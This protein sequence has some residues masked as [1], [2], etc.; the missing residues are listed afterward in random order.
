MV[1]GSIATVHDCLLPL[2]AARIMSSAIRRASRECVVRVVGA[3]RLA[4][5]LLLLPIARRVPE[6]ND[7]LPFLVEH[8]F[9]QERA[10]RRRPRCRTERDL[11]GCT[12]NQRDSTGFT[13]E[14]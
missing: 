5:A 7:V 10:R 1:R 12:G 13:R 11:V 3:R 4:V 8:A 9:Q 6:L 2:V 14:S